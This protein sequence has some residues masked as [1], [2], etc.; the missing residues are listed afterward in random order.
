MSKWV[1]FLRAINVSGRR[2]KNDELS[3]VFE[4]LGFHGAFGF[5]TS[6]NVVFESRRRSRRALEDEIS[7]GLEEQLG[8]SV[9]TFV[10]SKSEVALVASNRPFTNREGVLQVAFLKGI[11]AEGETQQAL[12]MTT[13]SD[14][15]SV[16]GR[17]LYWLPKS[18]IAESALNVSGLERVI[19]PMTIRTHR[20]VV[21]LA[22]KL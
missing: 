9:V 18:T 2:A 17:E 5:L 12:A 8:F 16:V 22:A 14:R 4:G 3:H 19:G 11:P 13:R 7:A 15:I 10:R 21:R 20:S 1:A 6:G